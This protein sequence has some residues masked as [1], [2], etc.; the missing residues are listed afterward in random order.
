[1]K[2]HGNMTPP[3]EHS[4][5][6]VTDLK[7]LRPMNCSQR[8]TSKCSKNAQKALQE[9]TDKQVNE[10]GKMIQE[11]NEKLNKEIET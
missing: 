8:T 6:P 9:N 10:I 2:N 7:K 5:L 1:M 4:Q 3:K 11:Q